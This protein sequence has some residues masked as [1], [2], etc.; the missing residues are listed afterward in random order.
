MKLLENGGFDRLVSFGLGRFGIACA[1]NQ[2]GFELHF[3]GVRVGDAGL[4]GI[5]GEPGGIGSPLDPFDLRFQA[6]VGGGLVG[7]GLV[8]Q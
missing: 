3:S 2:R 4:L 8:G 7:G 6:V 5:A 1:P